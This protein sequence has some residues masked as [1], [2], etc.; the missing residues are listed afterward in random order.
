MKKLEEERTRED[1]Q[2]SDQNN[3]AMLLQQQLGYLTDGLI[4][5]ELSIPS[6]KN[7]F[8]GCT[9][10]SMTTKAH[11]QN[12][13]SST[14][15][16]LDE[17]SPLN[18]IYSTEQT[19][20]SKSRSKVRINSKSGKTTK[21]VQQQSSKSTMHTEKKV[22]NNPAIMLKD[23]E[24]DKYASGNPQPSHDQ[25]I[26]NSVE[27]ELL[28]NPTN[29]NCHGYNL[30]TRQYYPLPWQHQNNT[31]YC[32]PMS[33]QPLE[34]SRPDN[35]SSRRQHHYHHGYT[36]CLTQQEREQHQ[37]QVMLESHQ[38][39]LPPPHFVSPNIPLQHQQLQQQYMQN[40]N[41]NPAESHPLIFTNG[42]SPINLS[43]RTIMDEVESVFSSVRSVSTEDLE[44]D[45]IDS[46][47]YSKGGAIK[48]AL[49]PERLLVLITSLVLELPVL[50][51]MTSSS[52]GEYLR[53]TLGQ[54]KYQLLLAYVPLICALSGN[55][56]LQNST[57]TTR[58]VSH[59]HVT[60]H[61]FMKQWV[62]VE[63]LSSVCIGFAMGC[64]VGALAFVS[65]SLDFAF[66]A[67]IG[68]A[69][70]IAILVAGFTGAMVPFWF[71]FLFRRTSMMGAAGPLI[72]ETAIQDI[73]GSFIVIFVSHKLLRLFSH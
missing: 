31:M 45:F 24:F 34:N 3:R 73:V 37:I 64:V 47:L 65:S 28:V 35:N 53:L 32:D 10:E 12:R 58:A 21:G 63:L 7:A 19:K 70:M 50:L 60:A 71:S 40:F 16:I 69:Q 66:G 42:Q 8:D 15:T 68:V 43:K 57:F 56:G 17:N 44:A 26:T 62:C 25:H 39:H 33:S 67:I 54:T 38:R 59:S 27:Q 11:Q 6:Y 55:C 29:N 14:P 18:I 20:S 51:M 1:D 30:M 2:R 41:G 13:S 61:T 4:N 46:E 9:K 36:D 5:S 22:E 48:R 52:T 72:L 49:F 23:F